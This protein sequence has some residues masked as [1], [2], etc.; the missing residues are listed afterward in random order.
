[1]EPAKL[2][3]IAVMRYSGISIFRVI[4]NGQHYFLPLPYL[5]PA[6][7]KLVHAL[8]NI[9]FNGHKVRLVVRETEFFK[10]ASSEQEYKLICGARIMKKNLFW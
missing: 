8:E 3:E 10:L 7:E 9:F 1:M 6:E 4:Q 2:D 5:E